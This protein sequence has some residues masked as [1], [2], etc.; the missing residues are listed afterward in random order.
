MNYW[1]IIGV[2]I[3]ISAVISVILSKY[4]ANKTEKML[5]EEMKSLEFAVNYT[6]EQ[7]NL[8]YETLKNDLNECKKILKEVK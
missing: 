2:C 3:V 7:Q 6:K 5:K 1:L 4:Y 8:L